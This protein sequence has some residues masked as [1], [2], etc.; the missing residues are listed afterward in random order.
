MKNITILILIKLFLFTFLV[1][2]KPLE[3]MTINLNPEIIKDKYQPIDRY[4]KPEEL[5]SKDKKEE[6]TSINLDVDVNK[7]QKQIDSL[8]LD[9]GTKF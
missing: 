4:E 6:D 2:A 8:K 1:N 3:E 9:V 5:P 7:E